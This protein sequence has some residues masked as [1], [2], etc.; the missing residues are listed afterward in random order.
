MAGARVGEADGEGAC[1][2]GGKHGWPG[3]RAWPVAA[4]LVLLAGAGNEE[5]ESV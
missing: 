4:G 1:L 2:A 5:D 3:L